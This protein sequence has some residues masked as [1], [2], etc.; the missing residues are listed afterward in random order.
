MS[1]RIDPPLERRHKLMLTAILLA[2]AGV[3]FAIS[4]YQTE[5]ERREAREWAEQERTWHHE[6]R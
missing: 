5:Q 1:F 6:R 3:C 2:C 4:H